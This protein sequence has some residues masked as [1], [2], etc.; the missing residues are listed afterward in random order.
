MILQAQRFGSGMTVE[1][2]AT[3]MRPLGEQAAPAQDG[4]APSRGR[5]QPTLEMLNHSRTIS[6][7]A[8]LPIYVHLASLS[9]LGI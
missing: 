5:Y 8:N 3:F 1:A 4:E 6:A 2:G 9:I 7:K